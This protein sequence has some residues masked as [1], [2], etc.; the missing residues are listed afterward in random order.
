MVLLG[1]RIAYF[2]IS[3]CSPLPFLC[4]C[5][6][7][8]LPAVSSSCTAFEVV[9]FILSKQCIIM[10]FII[11]IIMWLLYSTIMHMDTRPQ[12]ASSVSRNRLHKGYG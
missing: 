1:G 2:C 6:S 4:I 8:S 9:V 5:L 11:I 12:G 3:T 7:G 10:D